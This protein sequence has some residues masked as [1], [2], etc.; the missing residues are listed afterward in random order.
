MHAGAGI[1]R[2]DEHEVRRVG[3]GRLRTRDRHD[4]VLDRLAQHFQHL[5]AELRQLVQKEHTPMREADLARPGLS[6]TADEP[7]VTDRMVRRA[8]R[9]LRDERRLG[10]E[11]A[12]DAIDFRHVERLLR[13]HRRQD[14]GQGARQQ[15]FARTGRPDHEHVV[16]TARGDFKRALHVLLSAHLAE[17]RAVPDRRCCR[18]VA[19]ARVFRDGLGAAEMRHELRERPHRDDAH[20]LN[21]TCLARIRLRHVH[22]G[23]AP[24]FRQGDHGQHAVRVADGAIERQLSEEDS[25]IGVDDRLL[26]RNDH[27]DCD[28]QVIRRAFFPQIR[29]RQV[30]SD[31]LVGEEEAGIPDRRAS[32]LLRLLHSRVRQANDVECRQALRDVDLDFDELAGETVHGTGE[33]FGWRHPRPLMTKS[34]QPFA[35]VP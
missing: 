17:V 8:K 14:R 7:R 18:A 27:A 10:W 1:H 16:A 23:D 32:A 22:R 28:R 25:A 20:A 2:G 26:G 4:S 3:D 15:R 9:S 33:D 34:K 31:A 29:R 24:F 5:L 11:N 30:D 19:I 6:A 35:E 21:Q 12:G 13:R